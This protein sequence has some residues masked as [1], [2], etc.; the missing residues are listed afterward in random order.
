MTVIVDVYSLNGSICA[1]DISFVCPSVVALFYNFPWSLSDSDIYHTDS[2]VTA[3][4][5]NKVYVSSLVYI[6]PTIT[7]STTTTTTTIKLVLNCASYTSFKTIHNI[8]FIEHL[9]LYKT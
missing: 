9:E 3:S 6:E 4:D 2:T 1:L 8:L 7:K 5:R